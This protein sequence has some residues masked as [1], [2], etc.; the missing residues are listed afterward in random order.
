M[1]R[2]EFWHVILH[3]DFDCDGDSCGNDE[4]GQ[5]PK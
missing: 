2:K 5:R 3:I 1:S 4:L